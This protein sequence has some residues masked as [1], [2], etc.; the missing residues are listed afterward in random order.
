M[1]SPHAILGLFDHL[2]RV[3]LFV[4]DAKGRFVKVNKGELELHGCASDADILGKTDFDFH[5]P[6]MAMQYIAEDQRVMASGKP[7]A[8]QIWLVMGFDKMPRWFVSTKIP[9][10]DKNGQPIGI[11]GVMRHYEQTGQ[12]GSEYAR[13]TPVME[14][15][16]K[17]YADEISVE[18]LA[19]KCFLSVSQLQRLFRKLFRL[20][21]M[22]YVQRVRLLMSRRL[23]EETDAPISSIAVDCGFYD[24]SHFSHTFRNYTGVSPAAYRKRFKRAWQ[25]SL[26][27]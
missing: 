11:A 7:L 20:S 26:T 21:P 13:L 18:T 1:H 4:K 6:A 19:E 16:L 27:P 24:L 17:R 12:S 14:H 22:G 2:P 5:P 10:F 23:L 9:L 3:Y 25:P 8:D 15:V